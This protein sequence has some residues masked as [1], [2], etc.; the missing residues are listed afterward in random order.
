MGAI[1]ILVGI[2]YYPIALLSFPP[3]VW[4]V[5]LYGIFLPFLVVGMKNLR[6]FVNRMDMIFILLFMV[7][8]VM[9]SPIITWTLSLAYEKLVKRNIP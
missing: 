3:L 2:T 8:G 9:F 7:V 1:G 5:L 6:G 4:S